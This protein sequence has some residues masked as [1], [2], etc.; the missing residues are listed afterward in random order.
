M[1][2]A[3]LRNPPHLPLP[4]QPI[5]KQSTRHVNEVVATKEESWQ[6]AYRHLACVRLGDA[7]AVRVPQTIRR[8]SRLPKMQRLRYLRQVGID[9]QARAGHHAEAG[10]EQP[11]L[12]RPQ[13][14][15]KVELRCCRPA[16]RHALHLRAL[17]AAGQ[18]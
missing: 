17:L 16:A 10:K 15:C 4:I 3:C 14:L 8:G 18:G 7:V 13:R 12:Q 11:E 9:Q 1:P 6:S 5:S 2:A